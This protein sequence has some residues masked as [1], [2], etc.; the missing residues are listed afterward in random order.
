MEEDATLVSYSRLK[1][2]CESD[3]I[4]KESQ[5]DQKRRKHLDEEGKERANL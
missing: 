1:V 3:N 5:K 2:I 4:V